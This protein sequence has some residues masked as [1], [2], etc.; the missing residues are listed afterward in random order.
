MSNY[1]GIPQE[2]KTIY[3]DDLEFTPSTIETVDYA[4]YDYIN[5]FLDLQVTGKDGWEKVPVIWASAERAFQIKNNPE[6][7]DNEGTIIL[8]AITIERTSV[9]KDLNRRGGFYG[10]QFPIQT[11]KEKGG[12]LII[13]RRINQKKTSEFANADASRKYNNRVGPKFARKATKKVVYE[14]ISIPPIVYVS[15]N[16]ELTLRTEYQQQMNELLQPFVTKP[17]TINSFLVEREGH[18]YEA[19]IQGTYDLNN[20][21]SSMDNDER[22][23]E[24]KVSIEVLGYLIGED[25][26]QPTPTFAVRENAVEFRIPRERVVLEDELT[27]N[28]NYKNKG[29]DGKYRE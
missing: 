16:Y 2:D 21:I 27:G 8:P 28:N 6:Y 18:K 3:D 26:N 12:N 29:V 25:K 14:Y 10:N 23:F 5:G 1:T 20:N 22:K 13:A 17:G 11:Q 7:R 19:F 4:L 15:M 24:T 9:N